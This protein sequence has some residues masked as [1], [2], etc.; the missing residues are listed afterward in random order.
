MTTPGG[1]RSLPVGVL[2]PAGVLMALCVLVSVVGMIAALT[3]G[4]TA[5]P[6]EPSAAATRPLTEREADRLA[7][8]RFG[9][10]QAGGVH[11]TA[12]VTNVSGPLSLAGDLDT[13]A[14]IGYAAAAF[15]EAGRRSVA[16]LHWT[17]GSVSSWLDTGDG[18]T[19]PPVLPAGSPGQRA[20]QPANSTLDAVLRLLL[21]LSSDRPENGVLLRQSDARWLRQEHLGGTVAD[22]LQGPSAGSGASDLRYW[23]TPDARLLRVEAGFAGAK[24]VIDLDPAGFIPIPRGNGR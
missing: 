2:V 9:N 13:R 4:C 16:V 18:H 5:R 21:A 22:V 17:P 8:A 23:V 1:R 3:A 24:A 10:Y 15:T 11:F 14:H 12:T 7:V 19:P 20:L 6:A